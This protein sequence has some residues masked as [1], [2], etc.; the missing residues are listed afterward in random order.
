M[1]KKKKNK[2]NLYFIIIILLIIL[3]LLFG[4]YKILNVSKKPLLDK[5]KEIVYIYYQN[6]KINQK[7]PAI[8][9]K[10]VSNEVNNSINEFVNPYLDREYINIDYRYNISG[11]IIAL[12]VTIIDYS[13]EGAPD[14]SFKSFVINLR[15]LKV[16]D[17]KE[18]LELF[19]TNI[20]NVVN[21][22]DKQFREYYEDEIKKGIIS[23]DTSYEEY[24]KAHEIYNMYEQLYFDVVNSKL[25]IYLDFKEMAD[26][27]TEY[28]FDKIGHSFSY[29]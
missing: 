15:D 17:N 20:D 12:L 23:K 2:Y 25:I 10:N 7:V 5:S 22:I 18:V 9:I 1:K 3:L 24:L 27:E 6:E 14:Y 11:N 16:L 4:F 19:N 13:K 26:I 28:Y 8:N 21:V 29:E